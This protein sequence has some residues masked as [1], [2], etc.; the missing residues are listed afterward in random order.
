[1][2]GELQLQTLRVNE[3]L[4]C[5]Q[6]AVAR[7]TES[8]LIRIY[9]SVCYQKHSCEPHFAYL[10]RRDGICECGCENLSCNEQESTYSVCIPI[11]QLKQCLLF[12]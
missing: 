10:R 8:G 12:T 4:A 2:L 5:I 3:W 9:L 11:Q 7:N 1:M 6:N